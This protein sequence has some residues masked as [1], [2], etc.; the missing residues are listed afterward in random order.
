LTAKTEDNQIDNFLRASIAKAYENNG[1][2]PHKANINL[3]VNFNINNY[4]SERNLQRIE[5][6]EKS[7]KS[8]VRKAM[9]LEPL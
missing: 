1:P 8:E 9:R 7:Q 2:S 5:S 3:N 6:L 4:A